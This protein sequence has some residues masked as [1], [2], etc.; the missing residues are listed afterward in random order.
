MCQCS[1]GCPPTLTDGASPLLLS[2][3]LSSP[4][5]L[6]PGQVGMVL[7]WCW[8][9]TERRLSDLVALV[10]GES[11]VCL[12]VAETSLGMEEHSGRMLP[13]GP[14]LWVQVPQVLGPP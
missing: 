5:P 13:A 2:S 6:A 7:E 12:C 14:L 9:G 1:R 11:V 3:P 8:K 10:P 4:L